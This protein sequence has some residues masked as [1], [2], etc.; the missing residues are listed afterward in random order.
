MKNKIIHLAKNKALFLLLL[1]VFFVL[2]GFVDHYD[3]VPVTDALLLCLSY[4]GSA[5][6]VAG[7]AWLFFR[8]VIKASLLAL[9]IMAYH[10][11][12]GSVLDTLKS[13]FPETTVLRYSVLL[14]VSFLFFL[15]IIIGL[16]KRRKQLTAFTTYLNILLLF[17][18]L[19]DT[20]RLVVKIPGLKKSTPFN[21][22]AE[23]FQSCDTCQKPD[24][25]LILLDEYTGSKALKEAFHFDNSVFE[26]EL[27]N[28]G[29]RVMKDSRSNYNYTPFS[30]ASTL[31]MDYLALNMKTKGKGNLNYCYET[32]RDSRVV[33][34]FKA[35]GYQF[36][37][38]S[39]FYFPGQP[40]HQSEPFIPNKSKLITAQTFLSR[41]KEDINF[42]V[43]R[44]KIRFPALLKKMAYENL[45]NNE[46][47]LLQTKKT[48]AQQTA[49][50]KL[51]YAHLIMPHYPYYFNASGHPLPLEDLVEGR[52]SDTANYT[53]YLEYCNKMILQLTD[54]ILT[55]AAN[56]PVIMLL[57]DH[58]FRHFIP[59]RAHDYYFLNLNAVYLPRKNY[60]LFYDSMTNVNQFRV[61]LNTLF[62]QQLPLLKDSTI[63]LWE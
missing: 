59:K 48:A 13:Y 9:L 29:F 46:D 27:A 19:I 43:A 49:L 7:I 24:V 32:I 61:V 23:G 35:Q 39:T 18:I 25:Y 3:F 15:V 54:D 21:L 38:Y 11:F 30:M 41:L 22:A 1:P 63:Y 62:N 36:Y 45:H 47:I 20:G 52:E 34:F 16:K 2:H 10:F 33:K 44:G 26:N 58:G 12:Y 17:L 5:F 55:T 53:G 42:N 40:S 50:P 56:P 8:D 4:I 57:G 6:I 14:P 60:Q 31:N 28:R 51:V 37:N